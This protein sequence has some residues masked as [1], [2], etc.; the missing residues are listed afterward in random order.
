M[1][2]NAVSIGDFGLSLQPDS[3]PMLEIGELRISDYY[4]RLEIT[5]EGRFNLQTVAAPAGAGRSACRAS[6]Q[7]RQ[8]RAGQCARRPCSAACRSTWW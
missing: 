5:E 8:R 4:S 2:W 7:L 1:T 6:P 3:K